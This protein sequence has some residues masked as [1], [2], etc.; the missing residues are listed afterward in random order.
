M[1]ATLLSKEKNDAKFTMTFSAEDFEKALNDAYQAEKGKYAI[2]G[3]RKGKA[4][5]KLIEARFG[6][7]VFFEEALNGMFAAGYP[8]SLVD[9]SLNP[10]DRPN[11]D[12]GEEKLEKGKDFS[13]TVT[14]TCMPEFEVK[15]YK[16][17]RVEKVEHPVADEDVKK[18]LE[19]LQ[20]RNAR[21]VVVDREAKDGDTVLIDYAGFVGE[22]QFEGG[23]AERQPLVLGSK[24]F[25]PGF[26]EQLEGTKAGDDVEVKVTFPEEY[27]AEDL[28]GQEAVFKCKVHEVKEQ[29]LPLLD[30]DFA[31]DV[32]EF[33]TLEEL[34]VST[35]EKLEKT[36]A[37]AVEYETKNAVLE[38]V[39]AANEIDIPQI[40]IDDQVDEMLKEFE[41]QLKYQGLSLDMYCQYL[42]KDIDAVREELKGDAEKKVKAR[43]VVEAVAAAEN[44]EATEED[45]EKEMAAMAAQYKMEVEKLRE[46]MKV[47]N[48]SYLMQDIKMRKAIEFMFENAVI[49]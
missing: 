32:S 19:A 15:D 9:L 18:E 14:V 47:D 7:D 1:K 33:D 20:K 4:P 5:R 44:M 45:V 30:D 42:Q 27:H 41:Q 26:E 28:A 21:L 16:G 2:D 8:Q 35:R 22:E 3:F 13:V 11:V 34:K 46:M 48:L 36:A 10:V 37:E 31:K 6:A 29:E 49:E 17:V 25:I 43:L 38:K 24:T 39:Y 12:F 40:M 23:T